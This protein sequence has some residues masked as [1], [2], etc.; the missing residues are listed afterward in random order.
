M[1]PH[2]SVALGE[3]LADAEHD[4]V[5]ALCE[6]IPDPAAERIG[7]CVSY[8]VTAALRQH[9]TEVGHAYAEFEGIPA[10]ELA[11][12]VA[13]YGKALQK[14]RSYNADIRDGRINYRPQDHID[15]VDAALLRPAILASERPQGGETK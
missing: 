1:T 10:A 13:R 14:L 9:E 8:L 4:L 2:D 6:V 7:E 12:T 15:V 11:E 3:L 5:R